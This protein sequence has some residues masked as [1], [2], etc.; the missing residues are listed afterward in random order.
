VR[1]PPTTE[2]NAAAS[3]AQTYCSRFVQLDT[4]L[5]PD[6]TRDG[7]FDSRRRRNATGRKGT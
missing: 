7:V 3:L 4:T 1:P 6:R 2:Q 5:L